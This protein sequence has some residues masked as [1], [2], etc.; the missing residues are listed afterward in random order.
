MDSVDGA[1]W[2]ARQTPDILCYLPPSNWRENGVRFASVTSEE[3]IQI[4]CLCRLIPNWT[5]NRMIT[6]TNRTVVYKLTS[7][8]FK[9]IATRPIAFAFLGFLCC[10]KLVVRNN[11]DYYFSFLVSGP[12]DQFEECSRVEHW[13]YLF[14]N[15]KFSNL[16]VILVNS[17]TPWSHYCGT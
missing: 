16:K 3:I 6:Y 4:N 14:R 12:C 11:N 15:N 8:T 1:R 2:L 7:I 10:L 17:C 5:R 9:P 13:T